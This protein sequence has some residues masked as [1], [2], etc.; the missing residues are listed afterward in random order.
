MTHKFPFRHSDVPLWPQLSSLP[1]LMWPCVVLCFFCFVLPLLITSLL[2]SQ[3]EAFYSIFTTEQQDHV[4]SVEYLRNN[5]RP[6]QAMD[7]REVFKSAVKDAWASDPMMD[8]YSGPSGTEASKGKMGV[9]AKSSCCW[10]TIITTHTQTRRKGLAS[11]TCFL[12]K[13]QLQFFVFAELYIVNVQNLR[14]QKH[15]SHNNLTFL[16][17]SIYFYIFFKWFDQLLWWRKW[18]YSIRKRGCKSR[19]VKSTC[20]HSTAARE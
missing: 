18:P 7:N 3:L 15:S 20:V 6:T 13:L 5:H 1:F 4:K 8:S 9:V 2:S 12:K 11:R 19:S 14:G 16:Y 10:Q 17:F